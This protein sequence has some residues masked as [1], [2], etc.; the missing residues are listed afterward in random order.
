MESTRTSEAAG[1]AIVAPPVDPDRSALLA[2][3]VSYV[4]PQADLTMHI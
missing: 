2:F 1:L 4:L 3:D